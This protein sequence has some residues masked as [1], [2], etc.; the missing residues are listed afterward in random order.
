MQRDAP[1]SPP[2]LPVPAQ[3]I[4]QVSDYVLDNRAAEN[5]KRVPLDPGWYPQH[6][7][8]EALNNQS[9]EYTFPGRDDSRASSAPGEKDRPSHLDMSDGGTYDIHGAELH[10][11]ERVQVVLP[12]RRKASREE[13][14]EHHVSRDDMAKAE[15]VPS[16]QNESLTSAGAYSML[17]SEVDLVQFNHEG[18]INAILEVAFYNLK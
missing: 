18:H 4:P 2:P 5:G 12:S 10:E 11:A 15:G 14:V 17:D 8:R 1:S 9:N 7:E 16:W 13:K 6:R 3:L